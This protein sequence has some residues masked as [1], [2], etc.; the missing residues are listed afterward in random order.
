[1]LFRSQLLTTRPPYYEFE[2]M[3]AMFRIVTDDCPPIPT[4]ISDFLKD[5]LLKC[6]TKEPSKRPNAKDLL[7]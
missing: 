1:M 4:G 5:F 3:A 7:N 6:F 2:P